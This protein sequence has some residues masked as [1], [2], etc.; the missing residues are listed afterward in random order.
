MYLNDKA[1]IFA[2]LE[3]ESE[4]GSFTIDSV[5]DYVVPETSVPEEE[6]SEPEEES[7]QE[8]STISD[9]A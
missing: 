9:E 2:T 4:T 5:Y 1:Y 3:F 8:D 7:S 6:S